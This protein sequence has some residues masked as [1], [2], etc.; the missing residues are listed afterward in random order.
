MTV[1]LML[2]L[3]RRKRAGFHRNEQMMNLKPGHAVVLEA[4][5]IQAN[6]HSRMPEAGRPHHTFT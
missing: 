1:L 3:V 4:S 6:L 5:E 2:N